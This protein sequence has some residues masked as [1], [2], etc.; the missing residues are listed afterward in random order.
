MLL[1]MFV[2]K[3]FGH[4]QAS[5][6]C[7]IALEEKVKKHLVPFIQRLPA[8][9]ARGIDVKDTSLNLLFAVSLF[10]QGG[11]N[12]R[13]P[14]QRISRARAFIIRP[15]QLLVGIGVCFIN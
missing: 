15:V 2:Q 11:G 14:L 4:S 1:A 13:F 5:E 12:T 10:K 6:K 3:S 7:I 8:T 9:T